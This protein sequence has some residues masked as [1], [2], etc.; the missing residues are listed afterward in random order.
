MNPGDLNTPVLFERP[1]KTRGT[2]GETVITWEPVYTP[3][4]AVDFAASDETVIADQSVDT[5]TATITLRNETDIKP[6]WRARIE[7]VYYGIASKS[8]V[9][10]KRMY[11]Q[12][13]AVTQ[14]QLNG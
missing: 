9:D 14:K 1:V 4:C 2:R 13:T 3:F 8:F 5:Q 12:L 10:K 7:G 11:T 6:D